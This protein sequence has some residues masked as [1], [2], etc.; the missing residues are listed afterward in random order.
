MH[1]GKV[2]TIIQIYF[3]KSQ[4]FKPAPVLAVSETKMLLNG[5]WGEVGGGGSVA[6]S[7]TDTSQTSVH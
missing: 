5:R 6:S 3:A 1:L 4:V 2:L 7:N